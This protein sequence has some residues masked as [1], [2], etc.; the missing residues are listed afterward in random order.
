[1]PLRLKCALFIYCILKCYREFNALKITKSSVCAFVWACVTIFA[2]DRG[3]NVTIFYF[4]TTFQG[5]LYLRRC[6]ERMCVSVVLWCN[7]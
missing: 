5:D 4:C 6:K 3:E 1:M 2:L 7:V